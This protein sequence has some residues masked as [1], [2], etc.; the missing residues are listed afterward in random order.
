MNL[1]SIKILRY[2]FFMIFCSLI[3]ISYGQEK[4]V[5]SI[6]GF[7]SLDKTKLNGMH[8]VREIDFSVSG[9]IDISNRSYLGAQL[10]IDLDRNETTVRG[11]KSVTLYTSAQLGPVYRYYFLRLGRQNF[12]LQSS[13]YL[14]LAR[15]KTKSSAAYFYPASVFSYGG[16]LRPGINFIRKKITFELSYGLYKYEVYKL[17]SQSS[18]PKTPY[19]IN[20]CFNDLRIGV[21]F[22]FGDAKKP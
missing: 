15:E 16:N 12:Y 2:L 20:D 9:L 21:I 18:F 5:L 13:V 10:N 19:V 11:V 14:G 7:Y 8:E 3:K 6:V 22:Q 1:I 17:L 4:K